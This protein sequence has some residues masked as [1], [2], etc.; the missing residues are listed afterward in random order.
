MSEVVLSWS[1]DRDIGCGR[2]W[3]LT[4]GRVALLM[5]GAVTPMALLALVINP[6]SR[7][8]S[9]SDDDFTGRSAQEDI[10]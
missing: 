9:T 5:W 7:A 4:H 3:L 10:R 2:H 6:I 1:I 8:T